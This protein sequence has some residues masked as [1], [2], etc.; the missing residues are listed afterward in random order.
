M[1]RKPGRVCLRSVLIIAQ[2]KHII[3]QKVQGDLQMIFHAHLLRSR[4]WRPINGIVKCILRMLTMDKSSQSQTW[5]TSSTLALPNH[6]RFGIWRRCS[7]SV[8][9]LHI[10]PSS[11]LS[12]FSLSKR[13]WSQH[14][15]RQSYS[16]IL[17]HSPISVP[18][19]HIKMKSEL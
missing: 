15:R 11:K 3:S 1:Y 17:S 4:T 13:S 6:S 7:A 16:G 9:S 8:I 10:I 14:V 18:S 19:K 5:A 12:L 2:P